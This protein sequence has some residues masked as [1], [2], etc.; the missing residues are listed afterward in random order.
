MPTSII[1]CIEIR[2]DVLTLCPVVVRA[3]QLPVLETTTIRSA[4]QMSKFK[5]L[6]YSLPTLDKDCVCVKQ[7]VITLS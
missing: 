5:H 2:L 1:I 6:R 3:K 7:E 4:A